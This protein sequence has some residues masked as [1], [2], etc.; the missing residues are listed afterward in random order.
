MSLSGESHPHLFVMSAPSQAELHERVRRVQ[1]HLAARPQERLADLCLSSLT[2]HTVE[3]CR[4]AVLA[5][6]HAQLIEE[7]S[8]FAAGEQTTDILYE[9]TSSDIPPKVAFLF[10]GQGAQSPGMARRLYE[11]QPVFRA[12]I[13]RCAELLRPC[14]DRPLLSVLY[15]EPGQETLIHETSYTQPTLFTI[16]YALAEMWRSWGV[17]PTMVMGHSVGEYVAACIAGAFSLEDGLALIAERGRL[18][19]SLPRDGMMAVVFASAERLSAELAQYQDTVSIAAVNG[20]ENVVLSGALP[21]MNTLLTKLKTD[22]VL[23][24]PLTVSHA[25][26]SPLMDPILTAFEQTARKVHVAPLRIAL[27]SNVTGEPLEP[28]TLLD[29]AYWRRHIRAAVQF[30]AG[31]RSLATCGCSIFLEL[32]PKPALLGMG[33]RCLP[34]GKYYWLPSLKQ[35]QDDWLVALRSLGS[36]YTQGVTVDWAA[37]SSGI[38]HVTGNGG[39]VT[40]RI[41]GR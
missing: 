9:C 3:S 12:T 10:T 40:W 17:T 24:Q 14:L 20:P 29:A 39:V 8:G 33:R 41:A 21:T 34:K 36:L 28:G 19:Q 38:L 15:P 31:M 7:L 25:F 30:S 27:I 5:T 35:G 1:R 16:E 26:H 32:G 23:V 2:E 4:L 11:T 13:N 18:M 22:G 6:S 37:Y